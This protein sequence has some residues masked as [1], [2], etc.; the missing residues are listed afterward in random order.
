MS[1]NETETDKAEEKAQKER[2]QEEQGGKRKSE[3]KS[4]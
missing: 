4:V 1:K 3:I 2:R